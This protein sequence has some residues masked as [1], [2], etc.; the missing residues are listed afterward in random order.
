M[1]IMF[2]FNLPNCR[3]EEINSMADELM[4]VVL[5]SPF[6]VFLQALEDFC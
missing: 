6:R 1:H 4:R 5:I 2:S 3:Y